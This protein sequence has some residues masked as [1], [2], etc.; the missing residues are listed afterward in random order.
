MAGVRLSVERAHSI[1]NVIIVNEKSLRK[2]KEERF[3]GEEEKFLA[4][5]RSVL[6]VAGCLP[7]AANSIIYCW[8][9][10]NWNDPLFRHREGHLAIPE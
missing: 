3:V 10:D 2:D 9:P 1:K 6:S 7:R 5:V 4:L 8:F